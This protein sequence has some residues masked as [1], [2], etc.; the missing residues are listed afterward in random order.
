[1]RMKT[2]LVLEDE[3][4]V[5]KLLRHMLKQYS[6]IEAPT[7]EEALL[8]FIDLDYRVDLLFADLTLATRSGIQVAL[9][10]RSKLPG[11]PVIL[12]S[13]YPVSA[14]SDRDCADLERLGSS[15]VTI[16]RKPFGPHVLSNAVCGLIG[17]PQSEAVSTA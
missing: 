9:L 11:L 2:I 5:M 10:L 14:W 17:A 7:A 1:M 15:S 12:T 6:I 16:L 3:A 13:G 8:F 4:P